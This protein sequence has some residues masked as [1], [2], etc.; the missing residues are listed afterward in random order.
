MRAGQGHEKE[1]A[2]K[3]ADTAESDGGALVLKEEHPTAFDAGG[4]NCEL[5]YTLNPLNTHIHSEPFGACAQTLNQ[6]SATI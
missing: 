4:G 5:T 6:P 1:G 3:G 2:G